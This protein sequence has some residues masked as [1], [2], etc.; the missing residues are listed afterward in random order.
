[1][2][3]DPLRLHARARVDVDALLI[4]LVLVPDSYPRNRF[5]DLYKD[6]AMR[7][8]RRRAVSL[9]SLTEELCSSA[10][11]LLVSR[12]GTGF[13][14]H[15]RMPGVFAERRARVTSRELALLAAVLSKRAAP[16]ALIRAIVTPIGEASVAELAPVL[17]RLLGAG[18]EALQPRGSASTR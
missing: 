17:A 10:E 4:A 18:V 13:E 14:L 3:V 6:P 8:A 7:R 2:T 11:E 1:M 16:E 5:Y 15:Y 12:W 9:R